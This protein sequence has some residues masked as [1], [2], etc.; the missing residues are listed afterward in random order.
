M[1]IITGSKPNIN[2]PLGVV[3]I[4]FAA[5][6]IA[7]AVGLMLGGAIIQKKLDQK[8]NEDINKMLNDQPKQVQISEEHRA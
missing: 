2:T 6:L 7:F 5:I 8:F 3:L 1:S 4:I